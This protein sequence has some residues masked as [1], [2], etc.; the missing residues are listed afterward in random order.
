M[1]IGNI[2]I[3]EEFGG[4]DDYI[5]PFVGGKPL[6]NRWK[7]Q[8]DVPASTPHSDSLSKDLKRRGF[9]FVGTTI[10]YAHMQ[11]V[12]MVNDH[13]VSCFRH[14]PCARRK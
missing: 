8:S 2:K 5:W 7:R 13:L 14:A 1:T 3:Q 10:A 11:A 6:V 4:F 12:G 9:P